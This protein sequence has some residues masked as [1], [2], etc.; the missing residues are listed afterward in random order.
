MLHPSMRWAEMRKSWAEMSWAEMP[1]KPS[2]GPTGKVG[3]TSSKKSASTPLKKKTE[4]SPAAKPTA[5]ST[6]TAKGGRTL[7]SQQKCAPKDSSKKGVNASL[8]TA[9]TN[10]LIESA[11]SCA[12]V[13]PETLQAHILVRYNHYKEEFCIVNGKLAISDVDERFCLSFAFP[14]CKLH[15]TDMEG[16]TSANVSENSDDGVFINLEGD[17]TYWVLVE[18]DFEE[19]KLSEERNRAY[20]DRKAK[21]R[22]SPLNQDSSCGQKKRG[23]DLL[24]AELKALSAEELREAGPRYQ[25]LLAARDLEDCLFS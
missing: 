21:M 3:E 4:T 25:E 1:T 19:A 7:T 8:N 17:K 5:K 23:V 22:D 18:E 6:T 16:S 9:S 10:S 15:L 11:D 12:Q 20:L 14:K 24:T 2:H 13:K